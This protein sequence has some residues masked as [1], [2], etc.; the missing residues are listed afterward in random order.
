VTFI[1]NQARNDIALYFK[2]F[3]TRI[4][5]FDLQNNSYAANN[6]VMDGLRLKLKQ[7]LL[8]EVAEKVEEK[9]DS[10]NQQKPMKIGLNRIKFTNFN[11]DYGDDNSRTFAKIIFKELDT[12]IDQLDLEN[13]RF[14]IDNILLRGANID[15][16]LFSPANS[17][18]SNNESKTSESQKPLALQ[19]GKLQFDDVKLAYDNTAV[20]RTRSGIDFN[21]L[22]FSK[23]NLELRNFKMLDVTFAG[24]VNSAEIKES[25]GL[26]IQILTLSIIMKRRIFN[27]SICKLPARRFGMKLC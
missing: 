11:I 19:L 13:N 25:R 18:S 26:H 20:A 27:I 16:K 8:E 12:K 21:H 15:A 5:T 24:T 10:L 22:N 7:D 14:G 3:D 23:L 2:S 6:I 4:R 9:V 1:D 17:S